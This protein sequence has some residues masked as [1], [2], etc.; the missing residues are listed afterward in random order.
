M[1]DSFEVVGVARLASTGKSLRLELRLPYTVFTEI[2]YVPVKAV[3]DVI[4]KHKKEATV[5]KLKDDQQ[6]PFGESLL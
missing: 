3:Q 1:G 5:Y 4:D 2:C 6:N